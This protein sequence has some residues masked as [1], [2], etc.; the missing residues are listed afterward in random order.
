MLVRSGL[1]AI[2]PVEAKYRDAAGQ[3]PV[4]PRT[5]SSV[6][7]LKRTPLNHLPSRP[8]GTS[9]A[10]GA[11]TADCL[12]LMSITVLIRHRFN[13]ELEILILKLDRSHVVDLPHVATVR[14]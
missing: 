11:R 14:T 3:M 9:H 5:N 1:C 13:Q 12:P 7:P 10:L 4:H 8:Y 6:A 2:Q